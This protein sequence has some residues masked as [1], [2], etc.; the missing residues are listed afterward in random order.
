MAKPV[1]DR[2]ERDLA[3]EVNIVRLNVHEPVGDAF[4][5]AL[6]FQFVPT[7][8]LLDAEGSEVWRSLGSIDRVQVPDS[9]WHGQQGFRGRKIGCASE[10]VYGE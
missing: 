9:R 6:G 2:L 7:F 5:V 8:I 10:V 3:G 4:K 1:V